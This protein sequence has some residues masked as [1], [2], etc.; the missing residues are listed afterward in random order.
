MP[1]LNRAGAG[2]MVKQAAVWIIT[3][4][5]DYGDLGI[6]VSGFARTRAI[7]PEEAVRAMKLCAEAGIDLTRKKIWW[8]RFSLLSR[9]PSGSL[10]NWLEN[11]DGTATGR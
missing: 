11:F 10:Q 7:G 1:V 8:D 5:A 6:L 4:D 2:T 9:L 3:D